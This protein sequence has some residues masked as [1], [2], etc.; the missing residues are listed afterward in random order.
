MIFEELKA[1]QRQHGYLPANQLVALSSRVGVPLYQIH[2][3]ASFYPH[4]RLTQPAQTEV[5][6]CDD[7]ACHLRGAC[8]LRSSLELNFKGT[9]E[10]DLSID[11]VS[12]L[13]RCDEAPVLSI[14]DRIY[15]Q[16]TGPLA[17]GL[18]RSVLYDN[19]FPQSLREHK[20]IAC[21]SDPY[22][23]S[24]RYGAVR[25]LLKTRDWDG[26]LA[27]LK[28]S[29]LRG[30]GGAGAPTEMKW[31]ATRKAPSREKYI[32]CNADE[33]EPG[34]FKD[35]F[36]MTH[37]SHLMIEGMIIAGMVT[38]ARQGIVYI[39]HEYEEQEKIISQ[40]IRRCYEAGLLGPR[41]LG[42]DLSFDTSVFVSPGGYICGEETALLEAL[43][44]KRAEPRNKPPFP[45]QQ[46][47]RNMPTVVNNVETFAH[48]PQILFRGLERYRAQG[49]GGSAGLKFMGVS[50]DV[51]KPGVYEIPMGTPVSELIYRYAGGVR[52]GKALKA[53][54]P[55][56]PSGGFLPASMADVR[57]DFKSMAA[58]GSMLGS[59]A[60]VVCA[61]G[62]C[63][64]DMALNAVTFFRNESCGKCVPC[65]VGSQKM[66]DILTGWARGKASLAHFEADL[67]LVE[68]LSDTL[69]LTSICGLGQILPAP[70]S[71]VLKYFR[72]EVEAHIT[73][74]E[75]PSGVCLSAE[76]TRNARV[77]KP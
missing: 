76:A 13:G 10:K 8:E 48:V 75:C 69:R 49:V 62:T 24:E 54:A 40:E 39:R 35:R 18:V 61:R 32:I 27:T 28:A 47:L 44:G 17:E 41:I 6:V 70:V 37:L 29:E 26:V 68:H 34:T 56:G 43:E 57:L 9:S 11:R 77:W 55:S 14:N 46:G 63:M 7:M 21:A 12:C 53:F 42:N 73:R 16:L 19:H 36:I 5:H 22:S 20:E 30:L 50:G 15:T 67:A 4:F 3:V 1:I 65:R 72:E 58:A 66:V 33:S 64:L 31:S 38:G 52:D 60:M 51:Q 25:Q 71:S 74:G 2:G 23:G 59:G 45:A